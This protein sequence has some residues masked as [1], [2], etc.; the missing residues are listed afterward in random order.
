MGV[1]LLHKPAVMACARQHLTQNPDDHGTIAMSWTIASDGST[2]EAA[3]T[4]EE[5]QG[6][7]LDH[8]L[9]T[10]IAS[11]TFPIPPKPPQQVV[12]PFTF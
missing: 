6:G 11:W 1:V 4:S 3:S 2:A 7:A 5:Y 10:A 12:F 8:C 9:A